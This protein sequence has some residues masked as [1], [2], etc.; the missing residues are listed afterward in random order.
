MRICRRGLSN[1]YF[2]KS[3]SFTTLSSATNATAKDIVKPENP[4]NK[5]R[6]LFIARSRFQRASCSSLVS[7]VESPLLQPLLPPENISECDE[8]EDEDE[9]EGESLD[10]ADEPSPSP[11]SS[12]IE[13]LRIRRS[14]TLRARRP[15][16]FT[17]SVSPFEARP[18]RH[19]PFPTPK[20]VR[21]STS[22]ASK[23]P[24]KSPARSL[25]LS[26]LSRHAHPS[27]PMPAFD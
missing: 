4:L 5:R 3:K 25:S 23:M 22:G 11:S 17:V 20:F 16:L 10:Q 1:F 24:L 26:D 15:S 13:R 19:D 7:I 14:H 18:D 21:A 8:E 27:H 6:R 9:D 2:G 12:D